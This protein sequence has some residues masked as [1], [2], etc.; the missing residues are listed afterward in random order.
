[1]SESFHPQRRPKNWGIPSRQKQKPKQTSSERQRVTLL[2]FETTNRSDN[3]MNE[4]EREEKTDRYQSGIPNG[5]MNQLNQLE[6]KKRQKPDLN[7]IVLV[8]EP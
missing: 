3:G 2:L 6:H 7:R 1:M 5:P 4:K 8:L